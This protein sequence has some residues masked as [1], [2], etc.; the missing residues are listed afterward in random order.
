MMKTGFAAVLAIALVAMLPF[1]A[2]AQPV[3]TKVTRVASPATTPTP[4]GQLVIDITTLTHHPAHLE[5]QSL[6]TPIGV[7]IV[8]ST[9]APENNKTCPRA[10]KSQSECRQVFRVTLDTGAR[11]HAGGKYQALFGIACWPGTAA[12]LCK[13]GA[14]SFEFTFDAKRVC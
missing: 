11:C 3:T 9:V 4:K 10:A 6:K 14:Y 5:A 8:A 13:P 12:S 7:R 2:S 1:V